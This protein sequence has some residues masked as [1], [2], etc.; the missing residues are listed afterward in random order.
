MTA[1]DIIEKRLREDMVPGQ[2]HGTL[3]DIGR[4][5][6]GY[7]ASGA[8]RSGDLA[9][10][11]RIVEQ[12]S[13]N[14]KEGVQ[15][16]EQA[17][18]YGRSQP[19][20]WEDTPQTTGGAFGWDDTIETTQRPI[21]DV[22]WVEDADL[23]AP[24]DDWQPGDMIRYLQLMFQSDEHVGIV[25]SAWY[26]ET[27][28]RWLPKKGVCGRT[29]GELIEAMQESGGD[30]GAVIGD[31]NPAVGAWVRVNPLDGQGVKDANVTAFRHALLEAD[32]GDLGKQL[33]IIQELEIPCTCIVHSGGKS[34]HALVRVDADTYEEFR[35]RVDYLYQVAQ[36]NG[37]KV[38]SQN[39]NP[40]R[41]SRLPG[42][43]RGDGKQYIISGPCGRP[44]DEW[45][46]WV[47]DSKD[48]LPDPI[49]LSIDWDDLPPLAS[50]LISGV[51]RQGHKLLL[52]GPSK[53]GK[54]F[55]LI[56]LCIAI[57]EG[58][59]WHGWQC[60]QG[61]VMYVDLELDRP[62]C[63]HRFKA[64][65]NALNILDLNTDAIDIWSLRG[66]TR[67]LDKLA[68]KL[69]RRAQRRRYVA[70][71]IDPIYKTLT[72]SEND[73]HDMAVFCA[74]F[75][76]ISTELGAAV[77]YAHHHSKGDQ[78][79]KRAIDRSSGSGV[80]G[81]DPDAVLDLIELDITSERRAQLINISVAEALRDWLHDHG[82]TPSEVDDEAQG[83]AD[84]FLM[85]AQRQWPKQAAELAAVR[86]ESE[87]AARI[88]SG[89]RI[90]ATL[91]EFAAPDPVR[92]WFRY[93]VHV[94]DNMALL[95]DAKASGEEPPWAQSQRAKEERRKADAKQRRADL[96]EAIDQSRKAAFGAD[97]RVSD[98]ADLLGVTD[99][100]I[101]N[102]VSKMSQFRVE[103][104]HIQNA[105]GREK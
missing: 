74:Q 38:D 80:F 67:P 82:L 46:E 41:L 44:W 35:R 85:A 92:C 87:K 81:R 22:H 12:L 4:T 32:E 90:E 42:V 8:L 97:P 2:M 3:R 98:V 40:S 58:H 36:R 7:A 48:D 17:V 94:C 101:R 50:E 95:K 5:A 24:T 23:P 29:A 1:F 72:G 30:V 34:V 61:P 63:L 78:G 19:L 10:L 91:R 77:I 31:V 71:I 9:A 88:M 103:N 52:T 15:K 83:Q 70:V 45:E 102:R 69:I 53:A 89:W 56:E 57:A 73:A 64:A 20:I 25:A 47:E 14:P 86:Y 18:E 60:A 28:E 37:L 6:G 105:K 59:T 27:K 26:D 76:R 100:T 54:S 21:V 33:A 43:E 55:D 16:F 104:G 65:A 11:T 66:K 68:P 51:L 62:S 96:L 13:V 75:D 84:A 93:P 39:R 79:Q 99:K 49:A